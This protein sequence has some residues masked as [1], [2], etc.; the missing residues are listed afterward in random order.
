MQAQLTQPNL[1]D[2]TVQLRRHAIFVEQR[3]GPSTGVPAVQ[4]L[5]A[6]A[7]GRLL[8]V[9]DFPQI[10]NLALHHATASGAAVLDDAP[11]A[12]FFAVFETALGT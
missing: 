11:V 4:H 2:L 6:L 10:H 9:V 12:M 7:P 3:H 8:A 1:N 5:D